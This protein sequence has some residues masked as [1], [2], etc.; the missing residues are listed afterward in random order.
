MGRRCFD[1]TWLQEGERRFKDEDNNSTCSS[2][3]S[4]NNGLAQ[5]KY[6]LTNS[7][8]LRSAWAFTNHRPQI[9]HHSCT[10]SVL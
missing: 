6:D 9:L 7:L 3:N 2:S 8:L 5:R 1:V 4:N 10:R